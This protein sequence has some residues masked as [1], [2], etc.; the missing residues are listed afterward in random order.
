MSHLTDFH[1]KTLR[2]DLIN[3][4]F[5]KKTKELPELK[6]IT[7]NFSCKNTDLKN[8]ASS[9]LALEL[10][11]KQKGIL[12]TAKRSNITLKIRKDNPVGCKVSLRGRKMFAFLEKILTETIPIMKNFNGILLPKNPQKSTISY[13]FS[14]SFSF[15]E[16]KEHY[17][18]FHHIPKLNLTIVTSSESKNE[19]VFILKSV[20]IPLKKK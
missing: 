9:L 1:E 14:D 7:L 5:Y 20:Q 19:V 13:K 3:K 18:L 17:H 16:L 6:K 12:T 4:F 2:Y 10:I 11:T 8:L 15:D